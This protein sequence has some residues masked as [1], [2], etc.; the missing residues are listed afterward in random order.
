MHFHGFT[1]T[2]ARMPGSQA[3]IPSTKSSNA[4]LSP[5]LTRG[6]PIRRVVVFTI[7][8]QPAA[9]A[10]WPDPGASLDDRAME[11]TQ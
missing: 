7:L 1:D 11:L 2:N 6:P 8:S 10:I 3:R 5:R 9:A 4:V